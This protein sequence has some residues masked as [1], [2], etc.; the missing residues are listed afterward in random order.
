[1]EL[2]KAKEQLFARLAREIPDPRVIE[3]MRAVPRE[4]FVPL[5]S[6]SL[7]YEDIPLPI[8]AGQTISQPYIVALMTSA[9]D[10]QPQDKVLEVGTG[11]GYQAA[12]LSRLARKVITVER[13]PS[14]AEAARNTLRALG[15]TNV[16]VRLAGPVLGCPEEAPFQGIIVTAGAPR[17]PQVLLE[18]LVLGGRLVIPVGGR[19]EQELVKVLRTQDGYTVRSLGPCRFVPLIGPDG[20]EDEEET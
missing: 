19:T 13:I 6:R 14:L 3:A 8:G 16:E 7:A 1:M 4:C 9:L 15:Y 2:E 18:Q 10:L 12:V 11:S 17:L 5:P 20:W